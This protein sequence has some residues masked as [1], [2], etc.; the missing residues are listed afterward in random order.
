[1]LSANSGSAY[2]WSNGATTQDIYATTGGN[3]TVV[4]TD[5]NGCTATSA[6]V[7]I[8]VNNYSFT[9]IFFSENM[10]VPTA[11]TDITA[12]TGFQNQNVLLYTSSTSPQ[13]QVR[14]TTASTGYT[15]ASGG[16]NV[17][18]GFSA[19][20]GNNRDFII[21]GINSQYYTGITLSFGLLR[22]DAATSMVVETSTDGVNYTPLTV[23]QPGT[24][25]QWTKVTASGT[26]PAASNLYLRF[27]KSAANTTQFRI[28]D[29][30]L[31][32]T[33]SQVAVTAPFGTN[34]CDGAFR[35]VL[36]NI[37]LGNNWSN[38]DIA[39]ATFAFF[40]GDFFT[41]VT[42]GN[43]CVSYSDTVTM[44]VI[45]N[46]TIVTSTQD[47]T[48]GV[49]TNGIAIA[50]GQSATAPYTYSWN[51][52]P[53]TLNDTASNLIAGSYTVTV[54]DAN[55]CSA[56]TS[57]T[58]NPAPVVD[59]FVTPTIACFGECNGTA[60]P[61]PLSGTAPYTYV[62]D[63]VNTNIGSFYNIDVTPKTAAHPFFA[64]GNVNG[65]SVNG[66][67]GRALTLVRGVTYTFNVNATG[68]PFIISTDSI[69]GNYTGEVLSGVTG[70]RVQTGFLTFTPNNTHPSL[71]Y[72]AS[73]T[74]TLM[75]YRLNIVDGLSST[76]LA[77]LCTGVYT[78]RVVDAAGCSGQV[79]TYVAENAQLIASCSATDATCFGGDGSITVSATGGSEP[80]SGVGTF[81]VPAGNYTY[82]VTD[83][84]GC[85]AS[86]SATVAEPA[87]IIVASFTPTS[88]SVGS[89]VTISGSGFTGATDVSFNGTSA[90]FTVDNDGQITV[91][92]PVG[93]TS[94]PITV[95]VGSCSGVS[96]ANFNINTTALLNVKA[97][98]QG[99]YAGSGTMNS[100]MF[101]NGVSP[102]PSDCDTITVCLMDEF[103]Y[104]SV[105]CATVIMDVN[106]QATV[107][108]TIPGN[109]WIKITHQNA[110]QTWS[111][112][113]ISISGT[114]TYDFTTSF[115]QA[116]GG[117]MVEVETG[118]WAFWSGDT[119]QDE[120]IEAT[121]YSNVENDVVGFLFGYLGT[122]LTGDGLV[123]AS[124][125]SLVENNA[126][127]FLFSV[128]P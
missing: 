83:F 18:M 42:D 102:D 15:G 13:S 101:N 127:G 112:G 24:N 47:P 75:G 68:F 17:F 97:F 5:G 64:Q 92:V 88:G 59:L 106:G 46:P 3:Y 27:R 9:G 117:N 26:I 6:P 53:V 79:T 84:A 56:Q 116:F 21:S 29:I 58:L 100:P 30:Q 14:S 10:G 122:D 60:T 31:S 32:G 23:P 37:P 91:T 12:Y 61:T 89:S 76:S 69:A 105:A 54:T 121:D 41:N 48:C 85:T 86:C 80:Y 34:I 113:P 108:V 110:L 98:I 82:T 43:G 7:T 11:N 120:L 77:D 78:V 109:Y 33:A 40:G 38:G 103:T 118:I 81:N 107:S 1:L 94:G 62:W 119:N 123:E 16:G 96:A 99:Y 55:G 8:T 111:A 45:P 74:G 50:E 115:T 104:A 2:L 63:T 95:S 73:G 22:T 125:Y 57:V 90:S 4:V 87:E 28:D 71:L 65:Y 19:T 67:E 126:Q 36:S 114:T 52:V 49:D 124:D 35:P 51:T 20:L 25:N 128:H 70:S 93:A 39:Q 66:I 72:Y 44:T